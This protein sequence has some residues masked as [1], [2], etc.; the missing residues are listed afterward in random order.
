MD[1]HAQLTKMQQNDAQTI[2]CNSASMHNQ[3]CNRMSPTSMHDLK[4]KHMSPTSMHGDQTTYLTIET[5]HDKINTC[6]KPILA[7]SWQDHPTAR[8]QDVTPNNVGP[9]SPNSTS[10]VL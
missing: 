7:R 3:T 1:G 4:S 8:T 2:F 5:P 6:R 9:P 10:L